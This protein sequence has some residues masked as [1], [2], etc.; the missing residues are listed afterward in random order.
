MGNLW[1]RRR[2]G[3][4]FGAGVVGAPVLVLVLVVGPAST[5]RQRDCGGDV[6]GAAVSRDET[7]QGA[8]YI[9]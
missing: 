9:V 1:P 4:E 2:G 8:Y 7:G 3:G 6:G 5:S